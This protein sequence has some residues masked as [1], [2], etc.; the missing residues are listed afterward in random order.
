MILHAHRSQESPALRLSLAVFGKHPGWDDHIEDLGIETDWL[1]R[2]RQAFY[3]EGLGRNIESGAWDK[4]ENE[5][6]LVPFR[7]LAVWQAP[8]GIV[9]GRL[10]ASRDGKGRSKYPMVLLIQARECP[11]DW[12]LRE[13]PPRLEE[14]ERQCT[15]AAR[16]EDVRGIVQALRDDLRGLEAPAGEGEEIPGRPAVE[17]P[18]FLAD[19]PALAPRGEGLFR[20]LYKIYREMAA[21][22]PPETR[23]SSPADRRPGHLRVPRCADSV[24]QACSLWSGL[25]AGQLEPLTP[26]VFL[27]PLQE[28]WLD[29]LVGVP[30]V[31]QFFC[32]QAS[33]ESL[34]LTSDVPYTW[35]AEFARRAEAVV[36]ASRKRSLGLPSVFGPADRKAGGLSWLKNEVLKFRSSRLAR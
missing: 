13:M 26:L 31:Q 16:A 2:I 36:E 25:L 7:H 17:T 24:E 10:W 32:L 12:V 30:A 22:A 19:C 34:P 23:A 29:I 28:P 27:L 21:Y 8:E 5:G 14:A 20:V 4:L 15:T 1:I 33:P 9:V 35:D 11:L 18:A 6:R 3:V